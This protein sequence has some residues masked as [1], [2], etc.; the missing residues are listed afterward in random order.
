MRALLL[1]L[2]VPVAGIAAPLLRLEG[3]AT[4]ADGQPAYREVHWQRGAVDGAER[5]VY[6]L[7]P[8]GRPFARKQ[9]PASP[10]PQLRGYRL[11]DQ[12]SGQD[13]SIAVEDRVVRIDWKEQR[14]SPG[15]QA[16]LPLPENA[17]VDAGFDAAVRLHW[18]SL[19]QG[20]TLTLPFLVPG[21]GRFYPVRVQRVGPLR[22]RG[23]PAQSI[24]V[25]LDAWYGALVPRLS[26][27]YADA[28][29]RLLEFRG[30]S[31][32]RDARG[33]YPPVVVRFA[34]PAVELPQ[35]QWQQEMQ[36]P[37]VASCDVTTR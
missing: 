6:Y 27:V 23:Q 30:T 24:E 29:R 3:L 7:C 26:L 5:W 20:K 11:L 36:Q 1:L 15:R 13:A 8:D 32:L 4:T 14:S 19:M 22:W 18:T 17:V 25:R 21:R 34:E 31:N 12:R 33:D 9:M 28:D 2:C 35:Q 10:R 37:L 16:V